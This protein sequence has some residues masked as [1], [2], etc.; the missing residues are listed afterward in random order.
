MVMMFDANPVAGPIGVFIGVAFF[1][2]LA[3]VGFIVFKIMR[4]SVRLV[5]RAIILGVILTVAGAG[6]TCFLL[7]G[8]SKSPRP[9]SPP[10]NRR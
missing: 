2:I 7:I 1:L 4:R 8:T 6:G 3:A 5:F 10:A 9:Q